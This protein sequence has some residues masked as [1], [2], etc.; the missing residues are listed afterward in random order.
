MS[1]NISDQL[2]EQAFEYVTGLLSESELTSFKE[3][4]STDEELK[5]LINEYQSTLN[6]SSIAFAYTPSD[7]ELQSQ[8]LLLR[9]RIDQLNKQKN[10]KPFLVNILERLKRFLTAPQPAWAVITYMVIAVV[11]SKL[12]PVPIFENT[13]QFNQQ[14][15]N[16][17][18]LLQSQD[19]KSIK[20]IN[21]QNGD[22]RIH[23]A[24]ETGNDMNISGRLNDENIQQLLFYLLLKDDNPGKRLK[25]VRLL[26]DS[27]PQIEAQ[28]VLVSAL[29]TDT[30]PG[31]RLRSIKILKNYETSELIIDACIKILLEDENE[32]VRQHALEIISDHPMEKSLPV[33]Q[34]VSVMD[35]NEYIKA[36]ATM[37]LQ[38]FRESVEPDVIEVK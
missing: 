15:F 16:V 11:I 28:A 21:S 7:E 1:K 24:L 3:I 8:R 34:I 30:N 22:G 27:A 14:S 20:L 9:G 25:A 35:E 6:A 23:F 38:S 10:E 13:I 26:Q 18:D 5:K 31:V 32:A 29:L 37:M 33:L 12:I 19:L 36:Q 2:K 4:L 17:A